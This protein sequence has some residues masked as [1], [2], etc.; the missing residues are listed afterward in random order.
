MVPF[1]F[2][3]SSSKCCE[4]RDGGQLRA[5]QAN[6]GSKIS[7]VSSCDF[8]HCVALKQPSYV[9]IPR[10]RMILLPSL[11]K[12]VHVLRERLLGEH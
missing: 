4:D 7:R 10:R 2:T 9:L 12:S 11:E 3:R 8:K 5:R 1:T 6:V